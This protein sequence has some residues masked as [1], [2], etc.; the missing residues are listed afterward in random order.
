MGKRR[1]T[2][3]STKDQG[4]LAELMNDNLEIRW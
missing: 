2:V 4:K 3:K 1:E